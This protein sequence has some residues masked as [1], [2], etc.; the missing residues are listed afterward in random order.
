MSEDKILLGEN[1]SHKVS[2]EFNSQRS[3]DET[4]QSLVARAEL[5]AAQISVI[6]PSDP[7]IANKIEPETKGIALTFVKT[8]FVFGLTGFLLGLLAAALLATYGPALTQSSPLMTFIALGFLFPV[9][10]L[11]LAGL[12]SLRPD[13]D[14]LVEK[15]RPAADNG[16]WTVVVHCTSYEQQERVKDTVAHAAQTF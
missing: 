7:Y 11:M 5:P 9:L 8:H 14:S 2:A 12:L 10:G 3:A 13:H 1:F 16:R 4:V 15:A 6:Q